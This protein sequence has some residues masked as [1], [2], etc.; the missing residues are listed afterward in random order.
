MCEL[1]D[2]VRHSCR[3]KEILSLLWEHLHELLHIMDESHIEHTI[4]LIEDEY[5][6]IRE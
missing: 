3:E 6:D 5:L 1:H 4:R 2:L